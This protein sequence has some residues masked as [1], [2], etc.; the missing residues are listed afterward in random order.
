MRRD[1][2]RPGLDGFVSLLLPQEARKKEVNSNERLLE[3]PPPSPLLKVYY[4]KYVLLND[5]LV[6]VARTT[7][8]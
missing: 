2:A 1:P 4:N 8:Y 6:L 3:P 7:V 5:T